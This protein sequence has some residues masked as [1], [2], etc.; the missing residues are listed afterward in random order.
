M[1]SWLNKYSFCFFL[2]FF[3]KMNKVLIQ[4]LILLNK[5]RLVL[6][7]YVEWSADVLPRN[8]YFYIVGEENI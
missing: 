7:E 4:L 3:F 5:T 6:S 2:C 1:M 8:N